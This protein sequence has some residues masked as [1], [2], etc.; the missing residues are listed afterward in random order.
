MNSYIISHSWHLDPIGCRS[1]YSDQSGL[2]AYVI[3]LL[4]LL[5]TFGDPV[6]FPVPL[7][8]F[9]LPLDF[10]P[11]F[12]KNDP[13]Y[14]ESNYS[15][16]N[17]PKVKLFKNA[18]IGDTY[19]ETTVDVLPLTTLREFSMVRFMNAVTDKPDWHSKVFD[20]TITSKWRTEV[21]SSGQDFTERMFEWCID[22]LKYKVKVFEQSGGAISVFDG[23]VVKSDM[24][25]P[26]TLREELES[27]VRP[28][29]EVPDNLK[30][31]HPGSEEK[32][33]DLVHPS[34]FPL[35]YGRTRIL[36]NSITNLE[37]AIERCGE[38]VLLGLPA[39][40]GDVRREYSDKFQWLPCDVD[41]SREGAKITSYIN[42]LHPQAH[43]ALYHTI[44]KIIDRAIPLW[45]MTLSPLG[46]VGTCVGTPKRIQYSICVY[47]PDPES[48]PDHE[49]PQQDPHEDIDAFWERREEWYEQTRRVVKPQPN[50]F[51]EPPDG[52]DSC[53]SVDLRRDFGHR[54]LQVI[55]K[56]ANIHLTP[57]KPEY[58]GGSWH[59]EGQLNEHICASAIYYYSSSNVT[60]S[61]LAFRQL[62]D[63][64]YAHQVD[65]P[66]NHD[67]WL[68]DVFGCSNWG[69]SVQYIGAVETREGR[70]LT[71]PNIL[72]HQ[73]QPFQ[74]EDPT[75][76]G[77]RKILA[78]FLV[79][80]NI[81]IISTA[82][83]PCQRKDWWSEVVRE[84]GK[85][86]KG[87]GFAD[88]P[89][90]LQD[91]IFEDVDVFPISWKDAVEL[92]QELMEE[93]KNFVARNVQD[94]DDVRFSLCEH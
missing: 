17:N 14:L 85:G 72:Q 34:L 24:A 63:P 94:A 71:W 54:G 68:E 23:D 37:D 73:V 20:A 29:E 58:G 93:R 2:Q 18:L 22:E 7:P 4:Y 44:E 60:S 30:D 39:T 80:P 41:I 40:V 28:L 45:N 48:W 46:Y 81:R 89:T 88:L 3:V 57:D 86:G 8:G 35:V 50:Q 69:S 15:S 9:S 10:T 16:D 83:V 36:P 79:D 32:V 49:G 74:L 43:I 59:V 56:L 52:S 91:A 87:T 1:G 21:L 82:N 55:V 67:D 77:H 5:H 13:S 51:Q 90:E 19:E 66:Q 42:N 53:R 62:S 84:R 25:V 6:M 12:A 31:W 47:D 92:R 65:Y 27:V 26:A 61:S 11:S 70:L 64:E 38:G 75:K 76:E 78:L 33:L